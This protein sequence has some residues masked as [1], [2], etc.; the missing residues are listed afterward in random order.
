VVVGSGQPVVVF[1]QQPQQQYVT[2]PQV[3]PLMSS[4]IP[5]KET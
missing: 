2:I 3:D 4:A 1:T 5:G